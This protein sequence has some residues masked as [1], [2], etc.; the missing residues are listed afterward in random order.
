MVDSSFKFPNKLVPV[1]NQVIQWFYKIAQVSETR[2]NMFRIKGEGASNPIKYL[3]IN[4]VEQKAG[5]VHINAHARGITKCLKYDLKSNPLFKGTEAEQNHIIDK[6]K[7]G[8]RELGRYLDALDLSISS[9]I[10]N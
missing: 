2:G 1:F 10:I 3:I 8:E 6:E 5:F 9:S 4:I 7:V